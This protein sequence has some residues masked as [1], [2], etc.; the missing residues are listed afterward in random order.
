MQH[1]A[2]VLLKAHKI[3]KAPDWKTAFRKDF[4]KKAQA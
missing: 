3:K 1:H 4:M 2:D